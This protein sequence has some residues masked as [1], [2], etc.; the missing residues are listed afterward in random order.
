MRTGSRQRV[1]ARICS[2]ETARRTANAS[3]VSQTRPNWISLNKSHTIPLGMTAV[4]PWPSM[5]IARTMSHAE[6]ERTAK[7]RPISRMVHGITTQSLD[8]LLRGLESN[9]FKQKRSRALATEVEA[10]TKS[11][12]SAITCDV[13]QASNEAG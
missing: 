10:G 1:P 11:D 12:W 5:V 7:A 13:V 6:P 4:G 9:Y 8:Q 2:R 3:R